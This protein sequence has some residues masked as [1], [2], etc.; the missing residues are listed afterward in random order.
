MISVRDQNLVNVSLRCRL[1][2]QCAYNHKR[3]RWG[4]GGRAIIRENIFRAII[5][6]NSGIFRAKNQVKFGYFVNFSGKCHKIRV[7]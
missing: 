2:V 7:F 6:K 4:K 5:M 1:H 3:R